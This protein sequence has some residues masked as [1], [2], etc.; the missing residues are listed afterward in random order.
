MKFHF[1]LKIGNHDHVI[2]ELSMRGHGKI[3]LN[4]SKFHLYGH[5]FFDSVIQVHSL[6]ES[7]HHYLSNDI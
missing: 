7:S 6:L 5:N 2:S 4:R 3:D 1:L